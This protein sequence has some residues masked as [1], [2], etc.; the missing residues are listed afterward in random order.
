MKALSYLQKVGA[1]PDYD[2]WDLLMAIVVIVTDFYSPDFIADPDVVEWV[3]EGDSDEEFEKRAEAVLYSTSGDVKALFPHICNSEVSFLKELLEVLIEIRLKVYSFIEG[4]P[5]I[6]DSADFAS[7]YNEMVGLKGGSKFPSKS[8]ILHSYCSGALTDGGQEILAN[9][10]GTEKD[11]A[12]QVGR[13]K[14]EFSLYV[15]TGERVLVLGTVDEDEK[16]NPFEGGYQAKAKLLVPGIDE[17]QECTLHWAPW[18]TAK[19]KSVNSEVRAIC[20]GFTDMNKLAWFA[21]MA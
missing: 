12:K 7:L 14:S 13:L 15:S 4:K 18:P 11:F 3:Q 19:T 21:S 10:A 5:F 6:K 16:E 2:K 9:L 1:I 20:Q 8:M 17:A